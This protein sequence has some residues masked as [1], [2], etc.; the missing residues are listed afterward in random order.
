MKTY[1][2][3]IPVERCDLFIAN[4]WKY[5]R[6]LDP[7]AGTLLVSYAPPNGIEPTSTMSDPTTDEMVIHPGLIQR[8][9]GRYTNSRLFDSVSFLHTHTVSESLDSTVEAMRRLYATRFAYTQARAQNCCL[10]SGSRTFALH[11]YSRMSKD[12]LA[13]YVNRLVVLRT[14]KKQTRYPSYFKLTDFG[15]GSLPTVADMWWDVRNDVFFSFDKN[16]IGRLPAKLEK[17]WELYETTQH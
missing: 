4:G 8:P 12:Q 16:F 17:S 5:E 13:K 14:G 2:L 9:L 11:L 7:R 1:T 3:P 10:V 6:M 15:V